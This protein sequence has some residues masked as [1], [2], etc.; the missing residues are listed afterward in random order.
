MAGTEHLSKANAVPMKNQSEDI[1]DNYDEQTPYQNMLLAFELIK[2][3]LMTMP[4]LT[5][6]S[7]ALS[8][9]F[10][11]LY[12]VNPFRSQPAKVDNHSRKV[13]RKSQKSSRSS[14]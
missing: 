13:V 11:S 14:G 3:A 2:Q 7:F 9:L 10:I 12:L 4:V 5:Y 8:L 6:I 1:V